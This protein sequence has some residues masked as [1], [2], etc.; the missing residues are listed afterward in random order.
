MAAPFSF[1]SQT[2]SE[3]RK[4]VWPTREEAI[5]LT[6]VVIIV[7]I[8]VGVFVGGLDYIFTQLLTILVK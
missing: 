8:I 5:R 1:F 4:V 7:S 6:G 3:L 2:W